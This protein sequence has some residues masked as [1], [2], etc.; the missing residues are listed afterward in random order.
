MSRKVNYRISNLDCAN[1]AIKIEK[2]LNQQQAINKAVI[3]YASGSL[4]IN[5][6][7]DPLSEKEIEKQIAVVEPTNIRVEKMN[8]NKIATKQKLWTKDAIKLLLRIIV[9]F[10]L[11]MS[12][13][14]TFSVL[15][16]ELGSH[17]PF[18]EI[19]ALDSTQTLYFWVNFG[20]MLISFGLVSYDIAWKVIK[21]F[22]TP[23]TMLDENFLM[24]TAAL[25]AFALGNFFEA[26]L[27]MILAQVGQLF[28][29]ISVT[30]SRNSVIETINLRPSNANLVLENEVRVVEP[31]SLKIGDIIEIKLGETIPVDGKV[32]RGIG[33]LNTMSLTGEPK[34]VF[35]Q[36]DDTVMSGTILVDGNLTLKVTHTFENSKIAKVIELVMNSGNKKGKID[37]FLKKFAKWY[38][39]LVLILSALVFI[40]YPFVIGNHL[41]TDNWSQ[42]LYIAL[43]FLT[44]AC[45]CAILVAVPIAY[46]SGSGLASKHGL[47]IK[48]SNFLEALINVDEVITD[49]TGTLT[50]GEFDVIEK[51][52]LHGKEEV[53][54]NL[55][56]IAE[57]KSNHPLAVSIKKH[58]KDIKT[59]AKIHDFQEIPGFGLSA[60]VDGKHLLVGGRKL[61][62]KE[63][64]TYPMPEKFG[65]EIFVALDG[66]VI[67]YL[68]LGDV[69]K[70][71][72]HI[73]VEAL[74]KNGV[75]VTMLTGDSKENADYIAGQLGITNVVNNLLP[76]E[77]VAYVDAAKA[78]N[79]KTTIYIGDGINDAACII[80][81][82]VGVAMGGIGSDV[83]VDNADIVIMND[84][85][86]KLLDAQKIA[87]ATR[88][89]A[90]V[91]I[92][93]ALVIKL[94]LMI[95]SLFGLI[96]MWVAV[97]ADTG[98]TVV[99]VIFT[100][101][102]I[103]K[104]IKPTFVA[105]GHCH[106]PLT[107]RTKHN[108]VKHCD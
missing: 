10:V 96:D 86:S 50:K 71:D 72:A 12:S 80:S 8:I 21:S 40:I 79:K 37:S 9:S 25:G 59:T 85:P 81:S 56:V 15:T 77:K 82:D 60:Y 20:I 70:E 55:L 53:F 38:T 91:T 58:Y 39:P 107:K 100:S 30:K 31:S 74:R 57:R 29:K 83:S 106:L 93:V 69:I 46:F 3:D 49:K 108:E 64:I 35:V 44:V 66:I 92:I 43:T 54:T 75:K 47:I 19:G 98:L 62:E 94:A 99:S 84:Q 32:I 14:I 1:C 23:S 33:S 22:R 4:Q 88:T 41:W 13:F 17:T 76:E 87:K 61:L 52:V 67:G 18:W 11:T 28:E 16:G 68:V 95:L 89:R 90:I 103:S 104:K 101:L 48:G 26:A 102:L 5:Y 51:V 36:E 7:H 105:P 24:F 65:S 42:G 2:H 34:P 63:N 27:V 97:L 6:H 78:R 45:P 73:F